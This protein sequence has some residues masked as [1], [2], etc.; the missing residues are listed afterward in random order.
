MYN[1]CFIEEVK[2]YIGRDL[3]SSF[4]RQ[5][6]SHVSMSGYHILGINIK[7]VLKLFIQLYSAMSII[8]K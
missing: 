7:S 3:F 4:T 1:I 5:I 6:K 8:I 2:Y